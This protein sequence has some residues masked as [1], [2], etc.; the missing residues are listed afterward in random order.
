MAEKV[1]AYQKGHQCGAQ[2]G[3][4]RERAQ[5]A[6]ALEERAKAAKKASNRRSRA[7]SAALKGA[8][9]AASI[10]YK[11]RR[12]TWLQRLTQAGH[13]AYK[14]GIRAGANATRAKYAAAAKEAR[15]AGPGHMKR[16]I[17]VPARAQGKE[18]QAA[19]ALVCVNLGLRISGK[20][21]LASAVSQMQRSCM[22]KALATSKATGS[23][24]LPGPE[25]LHMQSIPRAH[26]GTSTT[27]PIPDRLCG[28]PTPVRYRSKTAGSQLAQSHNGPKAVGIYKTLSGFSREA[29]GSKEGKKESRANRVV[30]CKPPQYSAIKDASACSPNGEVGTSLSMCEEAWL[31]MERAVKL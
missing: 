31:A 14:D 15:L 1:E 3:A 19:P 28:T 20:K 2:H 6:R 10:A 25:S 8:A 4:A 13:L 11:K 22:R 24:P 27:Q 16:A 5:E 23:S 29:L 30:C 12:K 18:L 21:S 17:N 7:R 9:E 26:G